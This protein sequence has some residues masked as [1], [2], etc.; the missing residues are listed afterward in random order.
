MHILIRLKHFERAIRIDKGIG[1][2]RLIQHVVAAH[3]GNA[4]V[5]LHHGLDLLFI[6]TQQ[7]AAQAVVAHRHQ[8]AVFVAKLQH[9]FLRCLG[10]QRVARAHDIGNACIGHQL[11]LLVVDIVLCGRPED[12]D[13]DVLV[14]S[15]LFLYHLHSAGLGHTT[16]RCADRGLALG[17]G[18]DLAAR[19]H[20]C[21]RC[22]I[23]FPG[24]GRI[25]F[26]AR[27]LHGKLC[28]LA[29]DQLQGMLVQGDLLNGFAVHGHLGKLH[30]KTVRGLC[31]TCG[32]HRVA[33]SHVDLDVP[34]L[35]RS[36]IMHAG[37][38]IDARIAFAAHDLGVRLIIKRNR[39]GIRHREI[40]AA[41]RGEQHHTAD[42]GRLAKIQRQRHGL[43]LVGFHVVRIGRPT[44]VHLAIHQ[45]GLAPVFTRHFVRILPRGLGR[46]LG[47]RYRRALG[48]VDAARRCVVFNVTISSKRR[49]A[50]APY[51][52]NQRKNR[53][54][55]TARCHFH[56]N[57]PP[58]FKG[59]MQIIPYRYTLVKYAHP[60]LDMILQ[61]VYNLHNDTLRRSV[62]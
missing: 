21:D 38:F 28:A 18:G 31:R 3:T 54:Q 56:Q 34:C 30:Q 15:A 60:T 12:R 44:G 25:A 43:G 19:I 61:K 48:Y 2:E 53:A 16:R 23:R 29:H 26:K 10:S 8:H 42:L 24:H 14:K 33:F 47:D 7:I 35:G 58:F 13:H 1:I 9:F 62:I 51:H 40:I 49:N 46:S 36:K 41:A 4:L 27:K 32:F 45:H 17:L 5:F 6:H 22:V 37:I 55:N 52:Q 20:R 39:N 57:F 11:I 50:Q 59:Y